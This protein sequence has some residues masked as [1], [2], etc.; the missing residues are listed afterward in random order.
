M[1][2][3]LLVLG[4]RFFV[5]NAK[6]YKSAKTRPS[7]F[8]KDLVFASYEM[9]IFLYGEDSYRS[10]QKL[11]EIV[12]HYK[13][14][15]KSGL[16]LIYMDASR[17]DFSDFYN[18]FKV[19]SMFAETKLVILKNVFAN[20]QFQEDFLPEMKKIEALKDVV[21][22]YESNQPDQRLKLC[23]DLL[24]TCKCQEFKSLSGVQLKN[25]AQ[26][27]FERHRS[28]TNLD[29][30][31]L[32]ISYVSNDLWQLSN[33]VKKLVNYKNSSTLKKE[34]V[35]LLVRPKIEVDIFKTIDALASKN[36]KQALA[37]LQKHLESGEN[38]LYMLS[39]I[40][41]GFKNL[42]VVKELAE[43]GLMYNSIVKK[44]GLHPF[45]VKKNYFACREF[46]FEELKSIYRKVFQ[47][48]LDIKM[49]KVEPETALDLLISK[50]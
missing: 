10:K 17:A 50:I 30:L 22:I 47:I 23:K 18:T 6:N 5:Q 11:D 48:D 25:W 45:V 4:A 46:S 33:E 19:S 26:K 31:D 1:C 15:R 16:N 28:K 12:E 13:S 36:K 35:E 2:A 34:D 7:Q 21:V 44:S 38:P 39:M 43:K 42:L 37:L 41:W 9:I 20:K 24:K 40:A 29:A 27:E 14:V 49:G 3:K 8:C 32:L